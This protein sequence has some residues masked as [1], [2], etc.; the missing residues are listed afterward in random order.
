MKNLEGEKTHTSF[1]NE[2]V[3][4][5]RLNPDGITAKSKRNKK[6]IDTFY[7]TELCLQEAQL[8]G[9]KY[10]QRMLYYFL[11]QTITNWL[12]TKELRYK[13][14]KSIFLCECYLYDKYFSTLQVKNNHYKYL[15]S[16]IRKRKFILFELFSLL[17]RLIKK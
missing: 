14:R 12:R 6:S 13:Y 1:L 15:I 9:V 11:N 4:L 16:I 10:D 5:Y 8:Y 17:N 3:Y 7:I 2:C